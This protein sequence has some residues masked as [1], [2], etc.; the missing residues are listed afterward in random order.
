MVPVGGESLGVVACALAY[1]VKGIF[2]GFPVQDAVTAVGALPGADGAQLR[3]GDRGLDA[4]A[5][6]VLEV[7]IGNVPRVAAGCWQVW[8]LRGFV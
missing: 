5:V 4:E 2:N 6:Q 7:I 3:R 1:P 8:A